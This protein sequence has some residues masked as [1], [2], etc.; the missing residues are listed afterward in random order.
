MQ[1]LGIHCAHLEP[2]GFRR[3]TGRP[4]S[5]IAKAIHG[6]RIQPLPSTPSRAPYEIACPGGLEGLRHGSYL[7]GQYEPAL[8][9]RRR[10]AMAYPR[11][12]ERIQASGTP[13]LR[14]W[15][16]SSRDRCSKKLNPP[17]FDPA[18][19]R[20][21]NPSV[22]T[23]RQA[24]IAVMQYRKARHRTD[25]RGLQVGIQ[26]NVRYYKL[27]ATLCPEESTA[28]TCSTTTDVVARMKGLTWT[29][30]RQESG[31]FAPPRHSIS[32]GP[33]AFG[34]EPR[35]NGLQ[36]ASTLRKPSKHGREGRLGP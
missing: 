20:G 21:G 34:E 17:G 18:Q 24:R 9:N 33:R 1:E 7:S 27:P 8:A 6:L 4:W 2:R 26:R 10:Q 3:P 19:G 13:C 36:R 35:A 32:S 11:Q 28:A 22:R 23:H 12:V 29:P 16:V 5:K 31:T 25:T 15:G 30:R 14:T